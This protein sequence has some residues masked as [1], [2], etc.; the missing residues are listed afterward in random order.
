M[1]LL[2]Q[3][4]YL[5]AV[6]P[7]LAFG[8]V[9]LLG[10]KA[11]GRGAYLPIA[12]LAIGTVWSI[13]LCARIHS[14]AALPQGR[15]LWGVG[16]TG[17]YISFLVDGGGAAMLTM[18]CSVALLIVIYSQGYMRGDA[19][20]SRFFAYLSLFSAS[21]LGFV[22]SSNLL[23]MFICWELV[24]LMSYL[25]IGFWFHKPEAA[26]ACKKAFMTTRLGDLGITLAVVA[27]YHEAG[28]LDLRVIFEKV[29]AGGLDTPMAFWIAMGLF[30][31]AVGKSA[32]FPLHVWLPDAME[33]PT[34]VSALIHAAT[35]VAAGV[36]LVWRTFPVFAATADYALMPYCAPFWVALIG[37]FTALF[38][39]T[40]AVVQDDIKRVLAYSTISQLGYMML[41]L[42][43]S[44]LFAG[45]FHLLTHA[46]FKAC[47]FLG[48]GSVIIGTHHVQDM[49]KMGGLRVKMPVTFW[50]FVIATA[51][52][53]GLGIPGVV[54][55]SGFYSKD[56]VL[57]AAKVAEYPGEVAVVLYGFGQVGA[58]LTA[59]YMTRC[60]MLTF[61]TSP[62]DA[63]VFEHASET[64]RC[65]TVPLVVLAAVA[66]SGGWA[67][68]ALQGFVEDHPGY[69]I[70]SA[71]SWLAEHGQATA[72]LEEA[73]ARAEH[74]AHRF[75]E[76]VSFGCILAGV[77]LGVA[78]YRGGPE[79]AD[80]LARKPVLALLHLVLVNKYY[81]DHAWAAFVRVVVRFEIA[82]A[83]VDY[84][85]VD[86]IVRGV[87]WSTLR[88]MRWSWAFDKWV[89][90]KVVEAFAWAAGGLGE[91]LRQTQTGSVHV[92]MTVTA[93]VAVAG[94]L[95]TILGSVWVFAGLFGVCVLGAAG[96]HAALVG[97]RT[98]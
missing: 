59:F 32:Q 39:S 25:L 85:V 36:F 56:A 30:A 86:G 87:G 63:H 67:G 42:G 4:A 15:L 81:L 46:F 50:T 48:A 69:R 75:V 83:F 22:L 26:R 13:Y 68:H 27:L 78:L 97:R 62:R 60:V 93:G 84:W 88:V 40:M 41:A 20:Y 43:C 79:R 35:M 12:A 5:I 73:Q 19:H 80:A 64:P 90:D 2:S 47:L 74:Q 57:A 16:S 29:A 89:V 1:D 23:L 82:L 28:T 71:E 91:V 54:G 24:G 94:V 3:H 49:R 76:L 45:L 96:W 8:A 18:V 14:G 9:L 65:M 70:E 34:P 31:G 95:A 53:C 11:P 77:G 61:M 72:A 21:M 66:L 98:V 6:L 38:A 44:A 33:G 7:V 92:Y 51:A 58:L 55:L 10:Q 17:F 52:L 37:G